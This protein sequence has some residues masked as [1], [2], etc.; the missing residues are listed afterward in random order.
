MALAFV[1]DVREQMN[2]Y[3]SVVPT[4]MER[5]IKSWSAVFSGYGESS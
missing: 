5:L 1:N 2:I 3:C 4:V